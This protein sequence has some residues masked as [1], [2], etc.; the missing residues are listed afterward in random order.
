MWSANTPLVLEKCRQFFHDSSIGE[1]GEAP[2]DLRCREDPFTLGMRVEMRIYVPS[3]EC[4]TPDV[5]EA[6][7]LHQCSNEPPVVWAGRRH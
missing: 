7:A 6:R 2:F 1:C 5:K 3:L 4:L